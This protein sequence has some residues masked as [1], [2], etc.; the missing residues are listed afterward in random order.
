M[1]DPLP[2]RPDPVPGADEPGRGLVYKGQW[3]VLHP[4]TE[5]D[6]SYL[7][8]GASLTGGGPVAI[9]VIK[10]KRAKDERFMRLVDAD[11]QAARGLTRHPGLV[12]VLDAGWINGRYVIVSEYAPGVPLAERLEQPRPIP[13]PVVLAAT[14]QVIGLLAFAREHG[15]KQRHVELD[16]LI[17][18]EEKRQVRLLRF[19]S[20]RGAR[21]GIEVG[22]D[23]GV[24]VELAG[25]LL[26]RMLM[27]E[28]P[29]RREEPELAIDPLKA[30]AARAFPAVTPDELHDLA[31]LYLRTATR[32]TARRI[33]GLRELDAALAGLE[34]AHAPLQE[35]AR[36]QAL[37]AKREALFAT[38]YDTVHV[39][40]GDEP[41]RRA[42]DD[43]RREARLQW[44]L[45]AAAVLAFL[46]V[47][48]W[49]VRS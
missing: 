26:Y 11:L 42:A 39:L 12:P 37:E 23:P 15:I 6:R 24:D 29:P 32:D 17:L 16:H 48:T 8:L 5:T 21:L 19:S 18:D 20:G 10:D 43:D 28:P 1:G 40:R 41:G 25:S 14:R 44:M 34:S 7:F 4:L 49:L 9:K 13:Y 47:A 45:I 3:K 22:D 35:E 36:L 31:T 46:V 2:G 38:A 30:R 27:G 33:P